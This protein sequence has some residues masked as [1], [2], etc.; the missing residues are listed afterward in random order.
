MRRAGRLQIGIAIVAF[1]SSTAFSETGASTRK[2]VQFSV[3]VSQHESLPNR[4]TDTEVDSILDAVSKMLT[5]EAPSCPVQLIRNGAVQTFSET[6][7]PFSINSAE[8]FAKFKTA[9]PSLKIVGEINWCGGLAP[10]IIGCSSTPGPAWTVVRYDKTSEPILWAHEFAHTTGSRHR[11]VLH[12]LMRPALYPDDSEINDDECNKLMAGSPAVNTDVGGAGIDGPPSSSA[13]ESAPQ[14]STTPR[15]SGGPQG[16]PEPVK[17]F[18]QGNWAEGVP[19]NRAKLYTD[20]DIPILKEILGDPEQAK[21]WS[22]AVATLGAI[23]SDE[24]RSTLLDFLLRDPDGHLS[25]SEYLGKSNVPVALGWIVQRHKEVSGAPDAQALETLIKMTDSTWWSET[26][27]INWT[28]VIHGNRQD[29]ISSLVIKS[30]IGLAL[31]GTDEARVRLLQVGK[32]TQGNRSAPSDFESALAQKN[33]GSAILPHI[34][35]VTPATQE[36]VKSRGGN[37]FVTEMLRE[38]ADVK[39]KGLE[40]YYAR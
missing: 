3:S 19:Y 29:L 8:D 9:P 25:A 40:S 32:S 36:A 4:I 34:T 27:K 18:I 13:N 6:D 38:N 39:A 37:P 2:K 28:T 5:A 12:A 1:L 23:G 33:L 16:S 17:S 35:I 31:S 22:S 26:A 7:E 11:D 14:P 21:S 20:N 15:T 30:L 24:A 10:G